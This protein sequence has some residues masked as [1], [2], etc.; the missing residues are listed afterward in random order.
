MIYYLFVCLEI[1]YFSG[2]IFWHR[3][4]SQ[5]GKG[6]VAVE[7]SK[8]GLHGCVGLFSDMFYERKGALHL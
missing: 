7:I 8:V 2:E 4:K 6:K 3:S 5:A 1:A